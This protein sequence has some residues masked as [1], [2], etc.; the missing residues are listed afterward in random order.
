MPRSR[1][2]IAPGALTPASPVAATAA[3]PRTGT[4]PPP[5]APPHGR[6]RRT[7]PR[8]HPPSSRSPATA[9]SP[10]RSS[11]HRRRCCFGARCVILVGEM[12]PKIESSRVRLT[13]KFYVGDECGWL[14]VLSRAPDRVYANGRRSA[15]LNCECAVDLGGCGKTVSVQASCLTRHTKSC[16]CRRVFV[17]STLNKTHGETPYKAHS[18][19]YRT[20]ANMIARCYNKNHP[21]YPRYGGRGIYICDG[22]L[23]DF[24]SFVIDMGRKP[25]KSHTIDRIDNNGSYTCGHCLE[26]IAKGAPMNCR[27]LT[28]KEQ[29]TNKRTNHYLTYK[30]ETMTIMEWAIR[31]DISG[32]TLCRRIRLGYPI[33]VAFTKILS[34]EQHKLRD[35]NPSPSPVPR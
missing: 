20:R 2:Q 15:F 11:R 26:C 17:S 5:F 22:W 28:N 14:R 34:R 4:P 21:S 12:E 18:Q 9:P 8:R 3:S 13:K 31:L 7:P 25:T 19:E 1:V 35:H 29:S 23:S 30:G 16:G 6:V 10:S 24:K 27:W 32:S 33:D